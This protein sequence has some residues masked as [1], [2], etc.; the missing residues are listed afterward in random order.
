[1]SPLGLNPALAGAFSGTARVGGIYRIQDVIA[2]SESV[3]A[4][5]GYKTY[6]FFLDAPV[7]RGIRESHWVGIG[8][9]LTSDVSGIGNLKETSTIQ[10]LSYHI[11]LDK[12]NQ[13]VISF[14]VNSGSLSYRG[15]NLYTFEDNVNGGTSI[16]GN[17]F[18]PQSGGGSSGSRNSTI[19]WGAGLTY[20][21]LLDNV[22]AIRI[23]LAAAHL[24]N[25][26]KRLSMGQGGE[27][28]PVRITAFAEY[29]RLLG[30]RTRIIPALLYQNY[31]SS[32]EV[33]FQAL[34]AYYLNPEKDITVYGGAGLRVNTL[35]PIDALPIYLGFDIGDVQARLAY[36]MTLSRKAY[37]NRGFGALEFGVNYIL[38]IYKR[39]K[40]DPAI[41]CPRF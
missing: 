17:F 15:E 13:N 5:I 31:K 30:P 6:S 3:S 28:L 37:T 40:V 41:F 16:D 27:R 25:P 23:G 33:A 12:K 19:D 34:F 22:S 8:L 18:T 38:K 2:G 10:A 1:M 11:P 32:N 7:I 26:S 21:G 29:D 39:P 20:K 35:N 9:G 24:N 4:G 14:G 36:D